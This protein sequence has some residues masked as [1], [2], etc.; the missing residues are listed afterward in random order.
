[1]T[2]FALSGDGTFVTF[3]VFGSTL[4]PGDNNGL[5]DIYRYNI[6]TGE[7]IQISVD[8]TGT[9]GGGDG[10][11]FRP[12]ISQDGN[13]VVFESSSSNLVDGDSNAKTDIFVRDIEAGETYRVSKS[14]AGDESNDNSRLGVISGDG[15]YTAFMSSASNL[16]DSDGPG[17][18]VFVHDRQTGTT[19]QVNVDSDGNAATGTF[20]TAHGPAISHNGLFVV[21]DSKATD[22]VPDDT[23]G[24]RDTFV[25]NRVSGLT[26]LVSHSAAGELGDEDSSNSSPTLITEGGDYI[27]FDSWASNLVPDD[28]NSAQ[29]IFRAINPIKEVILGGDAGGMEGL[30]EE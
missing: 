15:R 16:V 28:T 7:V 9:V 4:V 8:S 5:H 24:K 17:E 21:F 29:D 30:P 12:S 11:S 6:L 20:S 14:S 3:S 2:P 1:M 19:T 23:N 18:D 10:S 25:H 26:R 22:L 13:F 27:I